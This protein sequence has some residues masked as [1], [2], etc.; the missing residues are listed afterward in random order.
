MQN[1]FRLCS[2]WHDTSRSFAFR[3]ANPEPLACIKVILRTRAERWFVMLRELV[4]LCMVAL[5]W[6]ESAR[7]KY[8]TGQVKR[9]AFTSLSEYHAILTC[10]SRGRPG[11]QRTTPCRLT[12][13]LYFLEQ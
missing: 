6:R 10:K 4:S 5:H 11:Q 7:N 12:V 13:S 3:L 8:E 1:N 9:I 2:L